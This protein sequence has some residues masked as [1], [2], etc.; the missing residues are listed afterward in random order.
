MPLL[1]LAIQL[2][3]EGLPVLTDWTRTGADI[4]NSGYEGWREPIETRIEKQDLFG[5]PMHHG[6]LVPTKGITRVS[7]IQFAV[8][9]SYKKM[10]D[11]MDEAAKRDFRRQWFSNWGA[12][13][14]KQ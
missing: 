14:T 6:C 8:I 13:E 4:W 10:Q 1:A 7:I 9:Y 5:S 2:P 3:P 12:C 11:K